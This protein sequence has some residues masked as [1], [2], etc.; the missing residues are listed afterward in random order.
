[1]VDETRPVYIMQDRDFYSVADVVTQDVEEW[2][3]GCGTDV[4]WRAECAWVFDD[5]KK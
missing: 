2:T 5:G 4:E 3:R 1:M